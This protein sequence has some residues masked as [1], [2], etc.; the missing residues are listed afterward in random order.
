[1]QIVALIDP[2]SGNLRSAE[3]ALL[4][5]A[6]QAN[7]RRE[8]RVTAD[9]D[10]VRRADKVVLPG[11]GAF[12]A[13]HAG[14]AAQAGLLEALH[15]AVI[16]R[17]AAFLGICVGMQLLAAKGLEQGEHEGLGWIGGT[18][19]RLEDGPERVPNMGW[20]KV[21][22]RRAHLVFDA[23]GPDPYVYFAHSYAVAE[24]P[25]AAI[26]AEAAHNAPFTAALARDNIL[27]VQFH[28]EKSQAKGLALL[29][30]FLD[31]TP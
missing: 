2:G 7:R 16:T 20:V 17:G 31:W 8:V 10:F 18:C 29:A 12:A 6:A 13:V 9:A 24:A 23:L 15:E 3:R 4:A 26:L 1:M 14:L 25:Q 5:A 27:G 30:R 11:Q 28:P 19:R 22:A 21:S